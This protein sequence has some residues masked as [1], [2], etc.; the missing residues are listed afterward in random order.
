MPKPKIGY[1][2]RNFFPDVLHLAI[3]LAI[4]LAGG[5]PVRLYPKEPGYDQAIDGLVIGGGTDLYPALYETDPKP[6][7]QYDQARDEM[8]MHWL[9][10][11]EQKNLPILGICRGAQM[12]NVRRG[13]SLHVD[14]SKVYEDAKY[15]SHLLAN[16]FFRK[17]I[18]LEQDTLL[19]RLLKTRQT[20]VNS[21]HKQA[22][23]RLG[24]NLVIS[25]KE[26]NGI[27]QAI[28]D[29]AR[30]FFIGVQFH[31]EVLIYQSRFRKLFQRLIET[32][33]TGS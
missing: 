6:D 22:I 32:A 20:R 9:D 31:P 12:M 23:D 2:T 33:K 25:A 3:D 30:D 15:P 18:F 10:K 29:P 16:I 28:E 21:M 14:V 27:V 1:T 13:G 5:K 4:R 26:K 11:A 19:Q 24:N 7:Y 17:T 8:E